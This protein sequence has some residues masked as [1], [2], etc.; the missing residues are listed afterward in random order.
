MT[1]ATVFVRPPTGARRRVRRRVP[2]CSSG[3][4]RRVPPCS[5]RRR[6]PVTGAATGAAR[7]SQRRV[8]PCSSRDG[9]QR[10]VPPCSSARR[11]VPPCSSRDGCPRRVPG[12]T[13]ATVFVAPRRVPATGAATGAPRDGCHRVRQ[14]RP[15]LR[16]LSRPATGDAMDPRRPR[17]PRC[18]CPKRNPASRQRLP[19]RSL[20]TIRSSSVCQNDTRHAKGNAP[21]RV[22]GA[23][24]PEPTPYVRHERSYRRQVA[25]KPRTEVGGVS[26]TESAVG[27][28][29]ARPLRMLVADQVYFVTQRCFQG[30]LLMTPRKEVVQTIGGV[31][32]KATHKYP[33]DTAARRRLRQQPLPSATQRRGA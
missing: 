7:V 6:V 15:L 26:G 16:Q 24:A 21:S 25:P 3:A 10:R 14:P 13:G 28:A 30:R 12:A 22:G 18:R 4:P 8:P 2:P 11:R 1:G 27:R 5:S 29:M 17:V 19:P 33:S 23:C 20:S 32:A 9:C 31:V